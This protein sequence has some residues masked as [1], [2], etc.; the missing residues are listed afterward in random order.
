M[1]LCGHTESEAE[2][3]ED[4]PWDIELPSI[5][6]ARAGRG[7]SDWPSAKQ[8]K[9]GSLLLMDPIAPSV[10][11]TILSLALHLG[12]LFALN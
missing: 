4:V 12:P 7:W 9:L 8:T 3:E 5:N 11:A 10:T 6:R 1:I 2:V